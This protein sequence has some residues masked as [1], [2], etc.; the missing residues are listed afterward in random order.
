MVGV[1]GFTSTVRRNAIPPS[2]AVTR[3]PRSSL[4]DL[5]EPM[6]VDELEVLE[7]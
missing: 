2:L 7:G 1:E 4:F 6:D 5:D 3:L